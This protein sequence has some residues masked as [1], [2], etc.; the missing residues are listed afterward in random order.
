MKKVERINTMMR[1]MNNRSFFTITEIMKEFDISRST[2][3]RDI[4]EI[5][6]M[7]MPL[8]SEV[9]R[10]G[11]FIVMNNS[12]LPPIQFTDDE[13]K[14]LFIAFMASRNQ[15]LPFLESRQSIAEKLLGL[16]PEHQQEVL[17]S[18]NDF[19][20]FERT[21]V[22]NPDLLELSDIAHPLLEQL[23]Q[24]YL[25]SQFIKITVISNGAE[26]SYPVFVLHLYR[27]KHLWMVEGFDLN[28]KVLMV[29]ALDKV[30]HV[31]AFQPS[32][33]WTKPKILKMI[34]RA[35]PE[36]NV[37]IILGPEGIAQYQKY[38]PIKVSIAYMDPFQTTGVLKM[39]VNLQDDKT[40][41]EL[42]NWILFLGQDITIVDLPEQIAK[43]LR[44]R[45]QLYN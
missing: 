37:E 23:I 31:E 40:L 22:Q 14:A 12:M 11:G 24:I 10:S 6:G 25:Y 35:Q 5:E 38:H 19:L 8:I 3:F 36:T 27:E 21:N 20:I 1:Y 26:Q 42:V 28:N 29:F 43:K 13:V 30:T 34:A 41:D 39:S 18:L 16:I 17:V 44:N 9:G 15:Q 4:K 2:A 33:K 45:S 7:G 32:A